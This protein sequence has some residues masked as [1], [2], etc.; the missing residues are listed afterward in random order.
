M[1]EQ[2]KSANKTG[3]RCKKNDM[4]HLE[5]ENGFWCFVRAYVLRLAR[6]MRSGASALEGDDSAGERVR[7]AN[8]GKEE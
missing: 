2:M 1:F 7:L 8:A 6:D 5:N 3:F 4:C